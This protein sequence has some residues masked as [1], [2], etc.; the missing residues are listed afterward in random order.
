MV[1]RCVKRDTWGLPFVD[2]L[3]GQMQQSVQRRA[4]G[5]ERGE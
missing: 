5:E 1:V 2:H 3:R 4:E